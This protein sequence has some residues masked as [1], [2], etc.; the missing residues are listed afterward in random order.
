MKEKK[1][2]NILALLDDLPRDRRFDVVLSILTSLQKE[3]VMLFLEKKIAMS[4]FEVR[5][6]LIE[7]WFEMFLE[8]ARKK[9]HLLTRPVELFEHLEDLPPVTLFSKSYYPGEIT[10]KVKLLQTSIST[11][12]KAEPKYHRKGEKGLLELKEKILKDMG[13]PIPVYRKVENELNSLV[14]TG[15][16]IVIPREKGRAKCLY[17]LNPKFVQ[18]IP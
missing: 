11:Y 1:E 13:V 14:T 6:K 7:R 9:E 8:E 18:K 4:V 16:L 2:I 12:N 10:V 3:I 17:A 5:K 15:L